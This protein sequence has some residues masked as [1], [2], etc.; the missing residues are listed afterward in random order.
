MLIPQETQKLKG[1]VSLCSRFQQSVLS[2]YLIVN[3]TSQYNYLYYKLNMEV[4]RIF[5]FDI[6]IKWP[7]NT[8][9]VSSVR[10]HIIQVYLQNLSPYSTRPTTVMS[11]VSSLFSFPC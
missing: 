10:C 3:Y 4:F 7:C 11:K 1:R 5:M 2:I 8:K 6:S 9:L